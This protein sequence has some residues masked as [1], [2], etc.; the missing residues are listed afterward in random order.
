M[1][2]R[3]L[4]LFCANK[5]NQGLLKWFLILDIVFILGHFVLKI[6]NNSPEFLMV[7][8]DGSLPEIFQYLKY[9]ALIILISKL[10]YGKRKPVYFPWLF[11][12]VLMLFDDALQLHERFGKFFAHFFEL[13]NNFGLRSVDFGELIYAFLVGIIFFGSLFF[14]YTNASKSDRKNHRDI[15]FLFL[16]FIFFAVGLD[17]LHQI[18]SHF[19]PYLFGVLAIAEDGGEMLVMS[20]MVWYFFNITFSKDEIPVF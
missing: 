19:N 7:D 4:T 8:A 3:L 14:C 20:L 9:V 6:S 18:S 10:I 2:N 5:E 11:L 15:L 13:S 12:F 16:I 1:K 17:M